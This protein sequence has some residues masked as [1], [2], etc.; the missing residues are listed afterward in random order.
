MSAGDESARPVRQLAVVWSLIEGAPLAAERDA[1]PPR[2]PDAAVA[3]IRRM[4]DEMT[5]SYLARRGKRRVLRQEPGLG[6]GRGPADADLPG[7]PVRVPV[8]ASD[9]CDPL[10][11]GCVPRGGLTA[12]GSISTS[13][14]R[15]AMRCW[16]WPGTG[17]TTPR[18]I[19]KVEQAHPGPLPP[20]A[21]RGS[22]RPIPR[23]VSAGDVR[24][25]RRPARRRGSRRRASPVS[26]SGSARPITRSGP[27]RRSAVTRSAG[28]SRCP[29]A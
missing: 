12:T 3:G 27:P 26:G 15:R 20:G 22:G 21:V 13:S 24:V 10:R 9:G 28:A 14:G 17:W 23:Q 7:R 8:P 29:P 16:R 1:A 6:P 11:P 18:S 2:V 19:S 25:H 5:G 4:L